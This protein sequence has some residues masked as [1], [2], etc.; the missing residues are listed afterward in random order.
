VDPLTGKASWP[1]SPESQAKHPVAIGNAR[2]EVLLAWVEGTAWNKG[3]SVAWQNYDT[4][5]N[6]TSEKGR[7]D[8]V[9]AWSLPT[10]FADPDGNFTIVY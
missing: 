2:G 4:D 5:L 3:G 6:P 10:A 9:A 7:A 8:G 1:V